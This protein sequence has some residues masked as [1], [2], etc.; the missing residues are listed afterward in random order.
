MLKIRSGDKVVVRNG[1][2]KGKSGIV[3]KIIKKINTNGEIDIYVKL[4]GL[5]LSKKH[6]KG[7]PN[8][9]KQGG[10]LSIESPIRYS[11]VSILNSLSNKVDKVKFKLLDNGK[12]VRVFKS[13]G[14][15]I[16]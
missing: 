5:N 13:N 8:K 15:V 7:N 12:K 10:I 11:N 6:S 1:K 9:N 3:S 16:N 2:D 14:E 4:E